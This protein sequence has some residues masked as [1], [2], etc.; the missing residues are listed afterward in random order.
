MRKLS[1]FCGLFFVLSTSAIGQQQPSV[2]QDA[3]AFGALESAN[4]VDLSPD[5]KSIVYI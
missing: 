3:A 1:Q 5:G 2:A 4:S